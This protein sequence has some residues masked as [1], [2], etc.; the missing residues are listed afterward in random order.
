V[1]L[2][3]V[4]A[5][6]YHLA[7]SSSSE[8]TRLFNDMVKCVYALQL[9]VRVCKFDDCC[10]KIHDLVELICQLHRVIVFIIQ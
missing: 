6:Y 5:M 7:C 9:C 4:T 8:S 10:S 3:S 2:L 1:K